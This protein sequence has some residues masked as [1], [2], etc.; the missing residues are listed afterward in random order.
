[1][2]P[3][4]HVYPD[5]DGTNNATVP[6]SVPL[7]SASLIAGTVSVGAAVAGASNAGLIG[8]GGFLILPSLASGAS[9]TVAFAMHPISPGYLWTVIGF[10][11]LSVILGPSTCSGASRGKRSLKRR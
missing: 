6:S 4:T 11:A 8:G 10:G 2:P 3:T 9:G 1:M 5:P 7:D